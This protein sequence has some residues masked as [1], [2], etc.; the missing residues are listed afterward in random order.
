MG[1]NDVFLAKLLA[2][3]C[4]GCGGSKWLFDSLVL[5]RLPVRDGAPAGD[6]DL[7]DADI[8]ATLYAVRCLG[9][10]RSYYE[11]SHEDGCPRCWRPG[12]AK[13]AWTSTSRVAVPA[14]CPCGSA[15]LLVHAYAPVS[16][17]SESRELGRPFTLSAPGTPGFHVDKIVCSSCRRVVASDPGPCS[18]CA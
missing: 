12:A 3:Q 11:R 15:D 7:R 13:H 6:W 1:I 14:T 10:D 18:A 17:I 8:M 9:C 16:T 4:A 5:G 2:R